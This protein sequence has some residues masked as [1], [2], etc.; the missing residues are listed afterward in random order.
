MTALQTPHRAGPHASDPSYLEPIG[1]TDTQPSPSLQSQRSEGLRG[2]TAQLPEFLGVAPYSRGHRC[3]SCSSLSSGCL[4]GL[5]ATMVSIAVYSIE[6]HS[7][8]F[9]R[10]PEVSQVWKTTRTFRTR[11]TMKI[12]AVYLQRPKW[13]MTHGPF[14]GSFGFY[15]TAQVDKLKKEIK[16]L[17]QKLKGT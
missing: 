4:V 3:I 10:G 5:K 16:P 17:A 6:V 9:R 1:D 15:W 2:S 11:R 12:G 14:Q 13:Y 8:T 7:L